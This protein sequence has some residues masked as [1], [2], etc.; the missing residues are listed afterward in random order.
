MKRAL[1]VLLV[2]AFLVFAILPAPAFAQGGSSRT[3]L[4]GTVTDKTGGAIPGAAV[5]VKN[6][7][8]GVSTKTITNSTGLFSVPALDPGTYTVTVTLQGFKT[9]VVTDVV[10]VVG[11]PGNV[12]VSLEIGT[13]GEKIT[14]EGNSSSLVQT[15]LTSVSSTARSTASPPRETGSRWGLRATS[16]PAAATT[17]CGS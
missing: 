13:I 6:N 2:F 11:N 10:L 4:S 9:A 5:D 15:Q 7:A 14:V 3:S 1:P 16:T 8:T 17:P 12:A